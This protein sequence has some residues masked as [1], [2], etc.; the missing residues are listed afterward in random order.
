MSEKLGIAF[1]ETQVDALEQMQEE[2]KADSYSEAG[3][4][5]C[6]VGLQEMGYTNGGYS[7]TMLRRAVREV[8]KL[9]LV[10]GFVIVGLTYFY[11]LGFRIMAVG[12]ILSGLFLL[13]VE[14]VLA[15]VEPTVSNRLKGLFGGETA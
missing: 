1:D 8:A 7:Q 10:A 15:S 5:A 2:G 9:F 13:G 11:P 6:A 12:P 3:R 14:R 4:I